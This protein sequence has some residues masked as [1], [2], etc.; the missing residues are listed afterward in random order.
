VPRRG[1]CASGS[2]GFEEE[3]A[4]IHFACLTPTRLSCRP[5]ACGLESILTTLASVRI[6]KSMF[7]LAIFSC[8]LNRPGFIEKSWLSQKSPLIKHE[9]PQSMD[10]GLSYIAVSVRSSHFSQTEY[11]AQ[12][13]RIKSTHRTFRLL[14]KS[15]LGSKSCYN[16]ISS[17]TP[18]LCHCSLDLS[19]PCVSGKVK[20][21][22]LR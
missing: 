10:R 9:S 11:P 5:T 22:A 17:D 8:K 18:S 14:L 12:R 4:Q 6:C 21:H 2:L 19:P 13:R 3:S 1:S 7:L 16:R 15:S 20:Q